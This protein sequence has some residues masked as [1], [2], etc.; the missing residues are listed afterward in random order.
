[1]KHSQEKALKNTLKVTQNLELVDV[2]F[3][4]APTGRK[5]TNTPSLACG[6]GL[7]WSWGF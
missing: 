7:V 1:M 6:F 4:M 2:D 3:E 5:R